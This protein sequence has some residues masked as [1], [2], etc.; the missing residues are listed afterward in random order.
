MTPRPFTVGDGFTIQGHFY[1]PQTP[2]IPYNWIRSEELLNTWLQRRY[3][4]KSFTTIGN[5]HYQGAYPDFLFAAL[6]RASCAV[7]CEEN[8]MEFA[9]PPTLTGNPG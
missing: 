7:F 2:S 4:L 1:H 9:T 3:G 5:S 6:E 8:R